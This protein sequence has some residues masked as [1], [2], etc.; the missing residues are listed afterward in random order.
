MTTRKRP[1]LHS[2]AGLGAVLDAEPVAEQ[3]AH[4]APEHNLATEQED[5]RRL[6]AHS[7]RA[8]LLARSE[9]RRTTGEHKRT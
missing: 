9:V 4:R 3:G 7:H 6:A 2:R 1:G 8:R 5:L